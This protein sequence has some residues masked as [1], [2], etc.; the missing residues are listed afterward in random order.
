MSAFQPVIVPDS[1]KESGWRP[2]PGAGVDRNIPEVHSLRLKRQPHTVSGILY[3]TVALFICRNIFHGLFS[4]FPGCVHH[5][6]F[7]DQLLMDR[8]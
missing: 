2:L 8:L 5:T 4:F 3:F 7:E 6:R 1:I